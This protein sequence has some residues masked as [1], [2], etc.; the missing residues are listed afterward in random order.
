MAEPLPSISTVMTALL[1]EGSVFAFRA[2]LRVP[3]DHHAARGVVERR[4]WVHEVDRLH[5]A[6]RNVEVD[7][8]MTGTCVGLVDGGAQ[9][10][11]AAGGRAYPVADV[12]VGQIVGRVDHQ[13]TRESL[14]K[15]CRPL[16]SLALRLNFA[17]ATSCTSAISRQPSPLGSEA[18]AECARIEPTRVAPRGGHFVRVGRGDVAAAVESQRCG[19]ARQHYAS[20]RRRERRRGGVG[21]ADVDRHVVNGNVDVD[22]V[23]LE[24]DELQLVERHDQMAR[25]CRL[26]AHLDALERIAIGTVRCRTPRGEARVCGV[27]RAADRIGRDGAEHVAGCR[28]AAEA[29][30]T[31]LGRSLVITERC[32][33]PGDRWGVVQQHVDVDRLPDVDVGRCHDGKAGSDRTRRS[34]CRRNVE[35]WCDQHCCC[36]QE[37]RLEHS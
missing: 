22:G 8:I 37:G 24:V 5:A 32:L 19:A 15:R 34:D 4:K 27:R 31:E 33:E 16:H 28:P 35:C 23:A 26:E 25:R 6:T 7:D 18:A 10:A 30:S 9:A 13:W 21:G 14:L 17:P 11:V 3:V 12:G 20:G 29:H 1:I 2:G 36:R